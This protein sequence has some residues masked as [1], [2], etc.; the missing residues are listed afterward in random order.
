MKTRKVERQKGF[1][2]EYFRAKSE[3]PEPAHTT[4]CVREDPLQLFS[5]RRNLG[6]SLK[7]HLLSLACRSP[8]HPPFSLTRR[9]FTNRSLA[10]AICGHG[11]KPAG[12]L[13]GKKESGGRYFFLPSAAPLCLL[14]VYHLCPALACVCVFARLGE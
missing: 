11:R 2:A 6:H 9:A 4:A 1:R 12:L 3:E 13:R 14:S 5:S 8:L 10:V 7:W